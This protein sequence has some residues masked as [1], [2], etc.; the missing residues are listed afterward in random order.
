[1]GFSWEQGLLGLLK[2]IRKTDKEARI[3]VLGLDNS[4]K[5]TILKVLSDEDISKIEPTKG[6]NTK[7]INKEGF[8]LT[9]WDIGGQ[10]KIREYW[11]NYYENN[12]ALV[13]VIDSA[14][15]KRMKESGDELMSLLKV[16]SA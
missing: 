14:D 3:L 8:K 9:V 16:N 12:D 13:Y 7:S 10:K 1:M 4:G 5:T 11:N 15:T 6:F 2:K